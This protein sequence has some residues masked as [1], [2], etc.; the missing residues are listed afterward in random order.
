MVGSAVAEMRR[1]SFVLVKDVL[2]ISGLI[3]PVDTIY[4]RTLTVCDESY[5][6]I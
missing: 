2:L 4:E 3:T 1:T 6:K 5:K